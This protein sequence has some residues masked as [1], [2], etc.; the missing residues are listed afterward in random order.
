[1]SFAVRVSCLAVRAPQGLHTPSRRN[2]FMQN[3]DNSYFSL[4]LL[5]LTVKRA[6]QS[7]P[8]EHPFLLSLL[9]DGISVPER[10][11]SC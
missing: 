11:H 4:N 9:L 2:V 1:M 10:T 7:A 3:H 5:S 8:F 6:T